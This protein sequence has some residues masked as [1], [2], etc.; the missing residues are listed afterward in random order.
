M[1]RTRRSILI[2]RWGLLDVL[3]DE[4]L[5][6][7]LVLFEPQARGIERFEKSSHLLGLTPS[8]HRILRPAAEPHEGSCQA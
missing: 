8:R 1:E 6:R 7:S 2:L 4:G 5:D 3:D